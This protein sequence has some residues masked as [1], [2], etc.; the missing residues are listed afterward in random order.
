MAVRIAVLASGGG[1]NL[2]AIIDFIAARGALAAG[3]VVLVASNRQNAGALDRGRT[4]SISAEAFDAS[5]DGSSLLSLLEKHAVGLVVLAGYLKRIPPKVIRTY[6]RRIINVHPGLLPDFGGPGMYGG[7]V[8]AAVIAAGAR[9][10]GVTAHFVDDELD[11]GPRIAVWRIPV[12]EDDTPESLA[13]RVLRVEH[14]VYPRVVDMVAALND[15]NYF[16]DF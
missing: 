8:H 2:Q 14:L 13:T 7:K 12:M 11:H 4:A 5:D 10:T 16:A 6:H 9:S 15:S 3:R 1:T